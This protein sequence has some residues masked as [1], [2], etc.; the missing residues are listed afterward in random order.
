MTSD[1]LARQIVAALFQW[2][3]KLFWSFILIVV[4]FSIG[5]S[6]ILSPDNWA[7]C[8]LF[9]CVNLVMCLIINACH[10]LTD[11]FSLKRQEVGITWC[12]IA[13]LAAIGLW[14]LAFVLVFG[15]QKDG[16][17]AIIFGI[18]GSVIGWIFQDKVKGAVTFVHMRRHHLLNIGD[19]IKVP[20]FSVEGEVKGVTLTTI[21][22]YNSDTT[23]STLPTNSLQSDLFINFQNML[24]GKTYGRKMD[25][26]FVVA[27]GG[28]RPL[29]E[30]EVEGLL[31]ENDSHG[32][33][34]FLPKED[35]HPGVLNAHLFRIYL[36][37]WLMSHPHISQKPRLLVRWMDQQEGGLPL[38]VHAFILDT[39]LASFEWQQSQIMEHIIESIGWFGLELFQEPSVNDVAVIQLTDKPQ[40]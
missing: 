30:K 4:P 20:K 2:N 36:Y 26:T 11:I 15:I 27:T 35:L 38:Q 33:S 24:D 37:H 17:T 25:R 8:I 10:T 23:T 9:L 34:Q 12:Q 40:S 16:S 3:G 1:N 18:V 14:I 7:P 19:Y 22:L 39:A 29:T 32:I 5:I 31:P 21:T 13:I 6:L 28:I